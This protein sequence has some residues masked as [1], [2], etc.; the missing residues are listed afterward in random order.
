MSATE[1]HRKQREEDFKKKTGFPGRNSKLVNPSAIT[2]PRIEERA[3]KFIQID[4]HN[5]D[6]KPDTDKNEEERTN[7]MPARIVLMGGTFALLAGAIS[8]FM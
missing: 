8:G 6:D 2:I 3:L 1:Q 7:S 5:D 4:G